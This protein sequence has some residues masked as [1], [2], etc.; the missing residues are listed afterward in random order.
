MADTV[1]KAL[2][3]FLSFLSLTQAD[4]FIDG[5]ASRVTLKLKSGFKKDMM[6]FGVL[7]TNI[8]SAFRLGAL[9]PDKCMSWSVSYSCTRTGKSKFYLCILNKQSRYI[10]GCRELRY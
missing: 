7:I 9:V 4:A 2:L 8:C 3:L 10:E 6:C 1:R 5:T